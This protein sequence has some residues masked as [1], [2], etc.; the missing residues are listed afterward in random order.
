[1]LEQLCDDGLA[2]ESSGS[3][4]ENTRIIHHVSR[5]LAATLDDILIGVT[6]PN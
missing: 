4:N 3:R 2:D 1:M 6:N 5:P